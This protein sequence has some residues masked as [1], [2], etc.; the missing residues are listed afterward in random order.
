MRRR[1]NQRH[2][3]GKFWLWQRPDN[4]C[5]CICWLER[6]SAGRGITRRKVTAF[7]SHVGASAPQEAIDALA[8]HHLD[9]GKTISRQSTAEALVED[10]MADWVRYHLP[11]L[12]AA[13]RYLISVNHWTNFFDAERKAGRLPDAITVSHLTPHLQARFRDWRFKAGV[14]GHTVSRDLA[15]LR[16]ALSSAWKNQSI[17]HPP[18][19]ADVP[20]HLKAPARDRV[21]TLEEVAAIMDACA[22]RDDREHIL[23]FI[24]IELGTAGRPEAVLELASDNIDFK[25]G[26]IDPR[27]PDRVHPRKRRAIVPIA[28]AVL[29]WV[30]G[31][32]GKIITYRV[33]IAARNRTPDGPTHYVRQTR[34]IKTAWKAICQE[35]GVIGAT[36]KTLRHTMLT[37]LA[38]KGVPKEQRMTLAG[39]AA[40][41]TTAKNYEHLS[42]QYLRAAIA[43][44]DI[45]FDALAKLTTAHLRY[46]NDTG[47]IEPL[48]A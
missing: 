48:A 28:N 20:T 22:N 13:D 19:I 21:L 42:P 27:Q 23:R 24:V 5:W 35:A 11:T 40:Q 1:S 46:R 10:L 17:E 4:G 8:A 36:P 7:R 15:A 33:P 47:L 25:R 38:E 30:S 39:H 9:F 14:G 32:R 41:D 26:L 31:I 2:Q 43:E 18:F 29:P 44:I 45:Y 34:C 6:H 3:C 12:Q 16:G 37:W